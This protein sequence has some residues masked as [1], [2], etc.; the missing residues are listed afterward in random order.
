MRRF[1]GVDAGEPKD[2]SSGAERFEFPR[3]R[4]PSPRRVEPCELKLEKPG[5]REPAVL[6]RGAPATPSNVSTTGDTPTLM[7]SR[8]RREKMALSAS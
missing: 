5:S 1:R 8:L 3:L 7:L 4:P 2:G 6:G